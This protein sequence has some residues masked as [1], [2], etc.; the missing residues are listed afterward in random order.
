M[1]RLRVA[2]LPNEPGD[3][4]WYV[5]QNRPGAF[6]E[7]ERDLVAQGRPAMVYEK[8]GVPLL[9][10]FPYRDVEARLKTSPPAGLPSGPSPE[11]R[12]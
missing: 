4:A 9:W 8:W 5:L 3:W 2:I 11:G 10:V 7:M 12:S 1:Q 6:R